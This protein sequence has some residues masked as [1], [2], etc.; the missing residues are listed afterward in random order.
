MN[1][2]LNRRQPRLDPAG[3]VS[4]RKAFHLFGRAAIGS[5]FGGMR[6]R[7]TDIEDAISQKSDNVCVEVPVNSDGTHELVLDSKTGARLFTQSV[8][9]SFRQA[10]MVGRLSAAYAQKG[11]GALKPMPAEAWRT[12]DDFLRFDGWS[13]DPV[14]IGRSGEDAP[15]WVFISRA[16]LASVSTELEKW[17]FE[18][19]PWDGEQPPV[20]GLNYCNEWPIQFELLDGSLWALAPLLPDFAERKDVAALQDANGLCKIN[21]IQPPNYDLTARPSIRQS[22]TRRGR[23]TPPF[24]RDLAALLKTHWAHV[25]RAFERGEEPRPHPTDQLL[26]NLLLKPHGII[27]PGKVKYH[28][29]K[30]QK[31]ADR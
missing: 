16:T 21:D 6:F 25:D 9:R 30:L 10:V 14:A 17:R 13:F 26:A 19:P 31:S 20:E 24:V 23:P 3:W 5:A 8:C 28:R 22:I 11:A 27:S 7:Q 4:L 1:K 15:C 2:L 29:L 12:D 18:L